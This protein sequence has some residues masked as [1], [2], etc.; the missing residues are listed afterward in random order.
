M[1]SV[2][3]WVAKETAWTYNQFIQCYSGFTM[4]LKVDEGLN[5]GYAV[6]TVP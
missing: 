5:V 3:N 6:E 2:K 1:C 4:R